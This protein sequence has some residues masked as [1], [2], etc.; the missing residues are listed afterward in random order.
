MGTIRIAIVA[1]EASGDL[2]GSHLVVALRARLPQAEFI[3]IAGPKM[4]AAGV[5][6]L[7]PMEKLSVIG[8][9]E[10]IRNLFSL[11]AMR[12]KLKR[13]LLA[14]RPHVYIGVDAPDFNFGVER[15]LR[16]RGFPPCIL[17]AL[18]SGLGAA[19]GFI[20]SNAQ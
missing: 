3:G 1:G 8:F 4:I 11:L 7:F 15:A 9:H 14:F 17:P 2:L 13:K 10:V 6:S 19:V 18:R 5:R 20:R 16:K 12:R